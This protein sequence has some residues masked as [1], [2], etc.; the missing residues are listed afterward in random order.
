M[1]P[2]STRNGGGEVNNTDDVLQISSA[3]VHSLCRVY[4]P[5]WSLLQPNSCRFFSRHPRQRA[6]QTNR[7]TTASTTAA[8]ATSVEAGTLERV[9]SHSEDEV[10][11]G[12]FVV[13]SREAGSVTG[14]HHVLRPGESDSAFATI[15]ARGAAT[16]RERLLPLSALLRSTHTRADQFSRLGL[17]RNE[18]GSNAKR[19]VLGWT[20]LIRDLCDAACLSGLACILLWST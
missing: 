4:T 3:L 2:F 7:Y 18:C 11:E 20:G 14:L 6:P 8:T 5:A 15:K 1:H 10:E 13:D 17:L 9:K 12:E 19:Y 16:V